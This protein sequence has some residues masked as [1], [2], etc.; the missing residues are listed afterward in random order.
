VLTRP[1]VWGEKFRAAGRRLSSRRDAGAT[2]IL[3]EFV[4]VRCTQQKPVTVDGAPCGMTN[5]PIALDAGPH[6]FSVAG[7]LPVEQT[8]VVSDTIPA[9]PMEIVFTC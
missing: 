3:M 1:A 7:C 9:D 5:N 8:V 2:I 4:I 6:T